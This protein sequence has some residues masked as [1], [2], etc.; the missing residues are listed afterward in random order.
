MMHLKHL[1]LGR[2]FFDRIPAQEIIADNDVE[3][4]DRILATRGA[5]YALAYTCNGRIF[6]V[7][8]DKL[9]F[10][11]ARAFWFDP[12][13]GKRKSILAFNRKGIVAFDPPGIKADG[14]DHVL[15]LEI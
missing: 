10:R 11:P 1:M 2:S 9:P 7:D 14:N 5:S 15:I 3:R 12:K 6:K 8:M 4:Y 13:S